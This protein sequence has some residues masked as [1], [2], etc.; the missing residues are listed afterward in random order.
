MQQL[1]HARTA[2]TR[3]PAGS[4]TTQHAMLEDVAP[5]AVGH[6]GTPDDGQ[7]WLQGMQRYT[8]HNTSSHPACKPG[9]LRRPDMGGCCCRFWSMMRTLQQAIKAG[10]AGRKGQGR[11][12]TGGAGGVHDAGCVVCAGGRSLGRL[13]LANR[14]ELVPGHHLDLRPKP[15]M[16]TLFGLKDVRSHTS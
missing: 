5:L 13:A 12:H 9:R 16:S 7:G 11:F 6:M 3:M 14:Q 1:L 2:C 4:Q 8:R 10:K 15:M